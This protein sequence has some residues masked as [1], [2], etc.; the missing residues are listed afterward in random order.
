VVA[1]TMIITG[2]F[3]GY[4]KIYSIISLASF[5]YGLKSIILLRKDQ[6]SIEKLLPAMAS[7]VTYSRITGALLVMS[8]FF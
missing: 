1:Y 8:L 7:T 5:P 2:V 4:T 6:E 3:F